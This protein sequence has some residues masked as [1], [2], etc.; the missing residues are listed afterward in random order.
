MANRKLTLHAFEGLEK[1]SELP[2][3]PLNYHPRHKVVR[4]TLIARGR[5]FE[6]FVGRHYAEYKD[7]GLGEMVDGCR[8]QYHVNIPPRKKEKLIVWAILIFKKINGRVIIDADTYSRFNPNR[9][10]PLKPLGSLTPANPTLASSNDSHTRPGLSHTQAN[11]PPNYSDYTSDLSDYEDDCPAAD[12][13]SE[14]PRLRASTHQGGLTDAQCLITHYLLPGF[15]IC[16]KTWVEVFIDTLAPIDWNHAA[17][18]ELAIPMSKKALMTTLVEAHIKSAANTTGFDDV[19]VG[20]GR[21]HVFILHGPPGVGKTL[22][23]E[24]I[25]EQTRRPLYTLSAGELGS[26]PQ[27]LT[28]TLQPILELATIWKTILLLEEADVFLESRNPGE[29]QR[30]MLFSTFLKLLD[31]YKGIIFITTN[32]VTVIDEAIIS[33]AH[34]VLEY[35]ELGSHERYGVWENMLTREG[36]SSYAVLENTALNELATREQVD[37]RMIRNVVVGAR[38]LGERRGKRDGAGLEEVAAML[39]GM[40]VHAGQVAGTSGKEKKS[41]REKC[42]GL[43]V[44]SGKD[45][46]QVVDNEIWT[47]LWFDEIAKRALEGEWVGV[48]FSK[49]EK[50]V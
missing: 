33:R 28:T 21:G 35:P 26:T 2:A 17:L 34:V 24:A 6:T 29:V 7:I 39:E 36:N 14:K 23:V 43:S 5:R 48:E 42:S 47:P 1:I 27:D 18:E 31:G 22:T 15:S 44:V 16:K 30:N 46:M 45:G 41:R 9:F 8:R 3:Y 50:P 38:G 25:A 11:N 37:G 19:I 49:F 32:R 4:R 10:G 12:K 13:P 40:G 20:K